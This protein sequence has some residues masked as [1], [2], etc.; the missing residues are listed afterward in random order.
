MISSALLSIKKGSLNL[1]SSDFAQRVIS[2]V[3][4]ISPNFS[5]DNFVIKNSLKN[6]FL[7]QFNYRQ[8]FSK[9]K[10]LRNK[11]LVF[12][13]CIWICTVSINQIIVFQNKRSS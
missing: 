1:L 8:N 11:I 5:V 6:I 7:V 9:S 2:I 4:G 13:N 3:S 10:K 12:D